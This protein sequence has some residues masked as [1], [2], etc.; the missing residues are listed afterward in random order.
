VDPEGAA[1]N[2]ELFDRLY[3]EQNP[4]R[5]VRPETLHCMWY[6]VPDHWKKVIH[7]I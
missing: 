4:P 5:A 1:K 7:G 6:F 3:A 2:N